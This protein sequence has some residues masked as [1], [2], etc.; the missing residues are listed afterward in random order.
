MFNKNLLLIFASSMTILIGVAII[1]VYY[2]LPT[3]II[4]DCD[5]DYDGE[6]DE[7]EQQVCDQVNS[8]EID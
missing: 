1:V 2:S 3:E 5:F 4:S 8:L 6:V 7:L